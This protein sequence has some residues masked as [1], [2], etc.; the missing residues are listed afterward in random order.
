MCVGPPELNGQTPEK[1]NR[2]DGAF[3]GAVRQERP[4]REESRN[5]TIEV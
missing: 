2:H 3:G 1:E 5:H 4:G